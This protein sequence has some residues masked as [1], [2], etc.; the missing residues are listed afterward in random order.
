MSVFDA[1]HLIYL[2]REGDARE[3]GLGLVWDSVVEQ[4]ETPTRWML[5]GILGALAAYMRESDIRLTSQSPAGDAHP[6]ALASG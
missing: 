6:P 2:E 1:D 5:L 3:V 4:E